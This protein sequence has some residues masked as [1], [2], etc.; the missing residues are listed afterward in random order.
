MKPALLCALLLS[1][2]LAAG[3]A[4]NSE[5]ERSPETNGGAPEANGAAPA[6]SSADSAQP[7]SDISEGE[8]REVAEKVL[9]QLKDFPVGW[10]QE[11]PEDEEDTPLDV[12]PE[13]QAFVG[14][15]EWPGTLLEVESPEF[16]GPDDEAVNSGVVVYADAEAARQ[17]FADARDAYDRCKEPLLQAFTGYL[18][19]LYQQKA[20]ESGEA[21]EVAALTMDW[22]SFPPYGDE[23]L[24]ARMSITINVG[25][26]SLD[27]YLDFLGWRVGRIE[28]DIGFSTCF[29]IPNLE[30]E[31]RLAQ[32]MDERLRKAAKDLD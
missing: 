23:S 29:E 4:S 22:L 13:C 31:Q 20:Q 26:R 2:A 32:I 25:T 19:Q 11:P 17:A 28:G 9:L 30:E 18:Q 10:S 6:T 27:C 15:E 1:L 14:E 12:P 21:A 8:A 5:D 3:C 24:T 16:E 7:V